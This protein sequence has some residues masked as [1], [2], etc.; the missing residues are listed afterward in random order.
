MTLEEVEQTLAEIQAGAKKR[1]GAL[2]GAVLKAGME[3]NKDTTLEKLIKAK[4]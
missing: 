2:V 1:E 3:K 4:I